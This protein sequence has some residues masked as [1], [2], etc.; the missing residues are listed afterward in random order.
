MDGVPNISVWLIISLLAL[1]RLINN[2]L[3][4]GYFNLG[5]ISRL[6]LA[7][8]ARDTKVNLWEYIKV[9]LRLTFT[10]QLVDK[11]S[12]VVLLMLYEQVRPSLNIFDFVILVVYILVF[13]VIITNAIGAFYP[14]EL[15]TRLFPIMRGIYFL[16]TPIVFLMVRTANRGRAMQ[17]QE[18][19]E[20]DPEDIKA[21]IKAG[22]D[23]G[24]IEEKEK[25]LLRNLLVFSDTVVREVMTPR[26]DMVCVEQNSSPEQI[27]EIFKDS[28]FSRL[29]IYEQTID[30]IVGI[31]RFKD[32]VELTEHHKDVKGYL[33]ETMFVPENKNISDLLQEM[34]KRRMQMVMV[35]DEYG[36][37]AGLITLED[38][39]EEIVGEIHD[40]HERPESDDI[41][42]LAN[43]DLLMDG[44]VTLEDF[45]E[46]FEAEQD[47]D[48][49]DTVG[50]YIF[51]NEGRIPEEGS[52]SFVCGV[53]VEVAKADVRRIYQIKI[54]SQVRPIQD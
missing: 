29:P 49:V 30:E 22:A 45:C 13:D 19:D 36:G 23:E 20:E 39:I 32:I 26:T 51:N 5:Q 1:L 16:T 47:N 9:P 3:K 43:G 52:A 24:I 2:L 6:S 44:K 17:D 34:L 53:P 10:T 28:K 8:K 21:F 50:G 27:L 46:M 37:T 40:E 48:D 42:H 14:E 35:I 4:A 7:E 41:I 38:L 31:L 11:T 25:D 33:K 54:S 18:D 15:V 12:L